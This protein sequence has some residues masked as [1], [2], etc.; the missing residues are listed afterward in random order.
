MADVQHAVGLA[1]GPA[2]DLELDVL[3]HHQRGGLLWVRASAV[4]HALDRLLNQLRSRVQALGFSVESRPFV[5]YLTLLRDAQEPVAMPVLRALGWR[6]S[7]IALV[8]SRLERSG[9]RYEFIG[10]TPLGDA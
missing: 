2:I 3:E 5:P 8:R 7:H 4:P 1:A 6:V 9:A 10:R